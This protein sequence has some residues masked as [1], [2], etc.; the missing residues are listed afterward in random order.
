[1]INFFHAT[2]TKKY[3]CQTSDGTT[4]NNNRNNDIETIAPH[5]YMAYYDLTRL[6]DN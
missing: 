2:F 3:L 1:M 5:I 6:S 4:I